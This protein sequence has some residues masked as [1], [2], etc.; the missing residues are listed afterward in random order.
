MIN[1]DMVDDQEY[2]LRLPRYYCWNLIAPRHP[3]VYLIPPNFAEIHHFKDPHL[4]Q[5]LLRSFVHQVSLQYQ[6]HQSRYEH[7]PI[8][9]FESLQRI[10]RMTV[11][12]LHHLGV[13]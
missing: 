13:V 6:R 8:P 4:H 11:W 12:K 3:V 10:I 2:V 7:E 1:L 5:I 9:V